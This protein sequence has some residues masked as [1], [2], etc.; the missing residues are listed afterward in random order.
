MTKNEAFG[1]HWSIFFSRF[2][3]ETAGEEIYLK[4][5]RFLWERGLE[6]Q[7]ETVCAVLYTLSMY[8]RSVLQESV[9]DC[10]QA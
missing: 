10:T 3:A 9:Q 5:G 2:G 6:S 8:K 1:C 7:F 4:C